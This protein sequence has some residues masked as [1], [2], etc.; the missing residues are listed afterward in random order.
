MRP[1][2]QRL[3]DFP[4]DLLAPYAQRAAQHPGGIVDLSVGTPVDPV[5]PFIQDAL[6]DAA[7]APGYPTTAGS[8]ELRTAITGWLRRM[9]G[10]ELADSAVL[11]TVGSKEFIA[12]LPTL[13][14]LGPNSTVVVPQIAYPTYAVGAELVGANVV[15]SDS[16]SSVGPASPDVFWLNSPSNPTGRVLGVEH[17]RKVVEWARERG[18]LVVSDECYIE[19]AWDAQPISILHP[20]VCGGTHDGLLAVHS[21]SKRSNLA[22]YRFGFVAG[23]Q[24]VVSELL[25]VRKHLG[26]MVPAPVQAA[27]IAALNDDAHVIE[28][29]SRYRARRA[30]LK[31]ALLEAGF[32]IEHGEAGLYLWATRGEPCWDTVAAL[33]E[34]GVLATPGDFYGIA[35]QRSIR[36][37]L[38][39]HDD[40]VAT[41]AERITSAFSPSAR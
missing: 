40:Q 3:P 23:D 22:G 29:R 30:L 9:L 17:L 31:A 26:M 2:S 15:V 41:A 18:T 21:L 28:Q 6:G 36:V 33:A 13:L 19:L 39:A 16:T 12:W 32:T 14:G 4:W 5:P 37:A 8:P 24:A 27:A 20:E 38:T 10:A 11:P 7:N 25:A 1:L 34:I 35:G